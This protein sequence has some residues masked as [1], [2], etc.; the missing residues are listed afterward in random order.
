MISIYE[1]DATSFT[2]GDLA[3]LTPTECLFKPSINGV[4]SLELTVP[5]DSNGKYNYIENDRILKVTDI[6]CIAEQTNGYQ[7]FRIYDFK[8]QDDAVYVIAYPVGL[9]ARFDTYTDDI[10][11]FNKTAE[12]ALSQ[13]NNM[14]NKYT[15]SGSGYGSDTASIE[16]RKANLIQII[17]GSDSDVNN[18]TYK[19]FVNTYDGEICYDNYNIKINHRLGSNLT[20]IDVRYGKNIT[21]MSY[22][23]DN[24][25]VITRLYPYAKSGEAFNG[26]DEYKLTNN[27]YVDAQNASDYPLPHIQSIETPYVLVQTTND[28]SMTYQSTMSFYNSIKADVGNWLKDSLLG[29]YDEHSFGGFLTCIELDWIV[30]N[31]ALTVANDGVEGIVEYMWHKVVDGNIYSASVKNLI[32]NAMKAGFDNV[33]KSDG[34]L[35]IGS[36]SK[37]WWDGYF[38]SYTWDSAGVYRDRPGDGSEYIW[39]QASSKWKQV[40]AQGTSTGAE[41]KTEWKWYKKKSTDT[42]KRFGNKKKN[43]MLHG[44]WWK[45]NDVW[46]W[47][48]GNGKGLKGNALRNEFIGYFGDQLDQFNIDF[49][50]SLIE[51]CKLNEQSLFTRLYGNMLIYCQDMFEEQGISYPIPKIEINIVDLSQTIEY[52]S[53]QNLEKIKLGNTVNVTNPKIGVNPKELRV[54]GLTYDVLRKCNTEIQIGITESTVI[55]LLDSI[56]KNGSGDRIISGSSTTEV[57]STGVQ[58]VILDGETCVYGGVAYID[59]NFEDI[60]LQWFEETEDALFGM[61][62][63]APYKYLIDDDNYK[64]TN[65]ATCVLGWYYASDGSSAGRTSSVYVEPCDALMM[66]YPYTYQSKANHVVNNPTVLNQGFVLILSKSDNINIHITTQNT[67]SPS[68]STT[69]YLDF[70]LS[71][72]EIST[73]EEAIPDDYRI[74]PSGERRNG[75]KPIAICKGKALIDDEWWYGALIHDFSSNNGY[76]VH[77][78]NNFIS[79]ISYLPLADY[80]SHQGGGSVYAYESMTELIQATVALRIEN[81]VIELFNGISREGKLAFF[82]GAE[83]EHGTNAP[84]KIFTDGT[85]EGLDKVEDVQ[86]EGVSLVDD[87]KI[88]HVDDAVKVKDVKYGNTSLVTDK[89]AQLNT[90]QEKLTA[91]TNVHISNQNVISATDTTYNDF[92]GSAHGL[93]P[94]ATSGDSGKFLKSDGTWAEAGGGGGS[95]DLDAVELTKAQ[96]DALTPEQKADTDKIYFV[97][98]YNPPSSGEAYTAGYGITIDENNVISKDYYKQ[99]DVV[100]F[101]LSLTPI[102]L[103]ETRHK[104]EFKIRLQKIIDPTIS[105]LHDTEVNSLGVRAYNSSTEDYESMDIYNNGWLA[106]VTASAERSSLRGEVVITVERDAS[107]PAM[108]A[109]SDGMTMADV[110]GTITI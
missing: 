19:S 48:N 110:T 41:D 94:P 5:Y 74:N 73:T 56:G 109:M 72:I 70:N 44:Q 3:V 26:I 105:I 92:S 99:G 38:Y 17:N 30:K 57:S 9:D 1:K 97:K 11:M 77:N 36:S 10:Q 101:S 27:R 71:E 83:D 18:T 40:N 42:Y 50:E 107:Y 12:Q 49:Y 80:P 81:T 2:Y 28:G 85:Y 68:W 20:P 6:D 78:N 76:T 63:T 21:G 79:L 4:W 43:R 37:K 55:N 89:I 14:S 24:S 90:L 95:S 58:D 31:Y 8:K 32:Y 67:D 93:V 23:L 34:A 100:N 103:Y 47:F 84:I 35:Y 53:Y 54:T 102:M 82:A 59:L 46:Y 61:V 87:N 62:N 64:A 33:L 7:L 69:S 52:S 91:G 22:D 108:G 25:N 96:Y 16:Y 60:G 29:E 51:S 86:L 39:I 45:I 98:D 66:Y 88:A 104:I 106:G 15:V 65:G 75:W 13:L